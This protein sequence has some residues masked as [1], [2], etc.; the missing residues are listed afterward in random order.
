MTEAQKEAITAVYRIQPEVL[1]TLYGTGRFD[2]SLIENIGGLRCLLPIFYITKLWDMSLH[3]GTWS[4]KLQPIL[5]D[6]DLRN[7]AIMDFWKTNFSI[8][9][10]SLDIDFSLYACDYQDGDLVY[11]GR[12]DVES[13]L[14]SSLPKIDIDLYR[15]A[16]LFNFE[17]TERLLQAGADG[18]AYYNLN[19][20]KFDDYVLGLDIS[21]R[22]FDISEEIGTPFASGREHKDLNIPRCIIDLMEMCALKKMIDLLE[23]YGAH[24]ISEY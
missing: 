11:F 1:K 19:E 3:D 18:Q 6:A 5:E 20:S 21:T 14:K 7:H 24:Y 13:M 9:V 10:S 22:F 16:S 17:E 23:S 12:S 2:K 8:D 4:D 15:A